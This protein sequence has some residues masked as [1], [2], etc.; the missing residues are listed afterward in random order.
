MNEHFP[1][2]LSLSYHPSTHGLLGTCSSQ[3][4]CKKDTEDIKNLVDLVLLRLI[5]YLVRR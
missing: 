2:C 3:M 5:I 1:V 4:L